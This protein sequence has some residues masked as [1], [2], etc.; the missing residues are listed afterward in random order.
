MPPKDPNWI[1]FT[2]DGREVRRGVVSCIDQRRREIDRV[3][4]HHG[5]AETWIDR[6]VVGN[7]GLVCAASAVRGVRVAEQVIGIEAGRSRPA[8]RL[9]AER[10]G[11]TARRKLRERHPPSFRFSFEEEIP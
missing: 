1:T 3:V 4:A 9:A 10:A 2:V 8:R 11:G 7:A 6:D 5:I